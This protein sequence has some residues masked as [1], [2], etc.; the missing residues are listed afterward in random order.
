[1]TKAIVFFDLDG[2]LL[3]AKTQLDPEVIDAVTQ[4]KSRGIVPVISTGRNIFEIQPVIQQ[5]QINTLVSGNG[6]YIVLNGKPISIAQI[7]KDVINRL[8]LQVHDRNDAYTAMNNETARVNRVSTNVK[9]T[10]HYINS[11]IPIIDPTFWQLYPVYM[12][13]VITTEE[14]D[15][16][17]TEN[18]K[19]KLTF[20]R[21][22]PYSID[23]VAPG[24]SKKAGIEK[25]LA[26]PQ[27]KGLP[28]YAFGDGNNDLPM[29][30]VV[31]HAIAMGNGLKHVQEAAE[32]VTTA[33]TNHGI[34]NGLKHFKLI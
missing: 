29:F 26:Q 3:N 28:T 25:L 21:Q 12:M 32:Y 1:M 18:F 34:V 11:P 5:T 7:P 24:V 33:N 16:A 30:D 19:D 31:D 4:L 10:Y 2:T 17:Y 23:V 27:F 22:T 9:K 13:L 14:N 8:T 20:F 15:K 6:S